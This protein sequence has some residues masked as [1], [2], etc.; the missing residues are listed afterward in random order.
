M[1]GVLNG[2]LPEVPFEKCFINDYLLTTF[3]LICLFNIF[4]E[5]SNTE[6]KTLFPFIKGKNTKVSIETKSTGCQHVN[7][8]CNIRLYALNFKYFF[9][10]WR[11]VM[12]GIPDITFSVK[13]P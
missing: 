1:T 7:K 9:F 8:H 12:R 4:F 3:F 10:K 13:K 5:I 6:M 11:Q 2:V